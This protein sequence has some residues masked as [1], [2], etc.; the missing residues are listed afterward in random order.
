MTKSATQS[1]PLL[2]ALLRRPWQTLRRRIHRELLARGFGDLHPAHLHVFQHPVPR[3]TRPSDLARN[4]EVTKQA[5]GHLLAQLEALG[6]LRRG[7]LPGDRRTT[8]IWLTARGERVV[9]E[10]RRVVMDVEAEWAQHLGR[11][12][13]EALRRLLADLDGRLD[14]GRSGS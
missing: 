5:M 13:L 1:R 10:I 12:R 4:A 14:R 11:R 6:Y 9:R 7:P 3:G 8:G 2:G